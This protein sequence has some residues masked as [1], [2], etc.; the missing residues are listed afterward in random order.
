[1]LHSRKSRFN[2]ISASTQTTDG[3]D[4]SGCKTAVAF[5]WPEA[6][7]SVNDGDLERWGVTLHEALEA[8]RANLAETTEAYAQLGDS[9]VAFMSGDSYDACRILL[10]DRPVVDYRSSVSGALP[11]AKMGQL[12][13]ALLDEGAIISNTGLAC[14]STPMGEGEV[15][16]FLGADKPMRLS[17]SERARSN[18]A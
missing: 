8:G 10:T 4:L 16:R 18:L 17:L 7:Q 14:L 11:P 3:V 13:R 5:D 1:M 15:D 9:L 12:H 6:T 2:V